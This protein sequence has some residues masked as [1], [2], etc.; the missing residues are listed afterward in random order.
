MSANATP[1][2]RNRG[3]DAACTVAAAQRSRTPRRNLRADELHH[4]EEE[5][6]GGTQRCSG[7]GGDDIRHIQLDNRLWYTVD[8]IELALKMDP[9]AL[10]GE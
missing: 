4:T 2:R 1:L 6:S 8:A 5:H 9:G 7:V 3:A 10:R